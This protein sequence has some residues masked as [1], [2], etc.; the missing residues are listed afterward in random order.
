MTQLNYDDVRN[1]R[2]DIVGQA[3]QVGGQMLQPQGSIDCGEVG[4]V[5]VQALMQAGQP[6]PI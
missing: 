1:S 4:P 6:I 2:P 5:P 3:L